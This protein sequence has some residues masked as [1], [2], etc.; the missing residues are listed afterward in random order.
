MKFISKVKNTIFSTIICTIISCIMM[1]IFFPIFIVDH[2]LVIYR[3]ITILLTIFFSMIILGIWHGRKSSIRFFNSSS[4]FFVWS[5][6][7]YLITIKYYPV[8][9]IEPVIIITLLSVFIYML[10]IFIGKK[11][12]HNSYFIS[13]SHKNKGIADKVQKYLTDTKT[14]V[15]RDEKQVRVGH[16]L[17]TELKQMIN[18]S[19]TSIVLWDYHYKNSEW[20]MYEL[21][22]SYE[23]GKNI[24]FGK[25]D[26]TS[27][28][29][30]HSDLVMC[31]WEDK[32]IR[33][34]IIEK[35]ILKIKMNDQ[36]SRCLTTKRHNPLK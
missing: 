31:N 4:F 6:N 29:K 22:Y 32:I 5:V 36:R 17:S 12:K 13:Y 34:I 23:Q 28:P 9:L 27:I 19:D 16:Q 7:G 35:D 10:G 21:R 18:K 2:D 8:N 25:L 3:D 33:D 11:T 14:K 24:I 1:L 30:E 20:C 15:L 26:D